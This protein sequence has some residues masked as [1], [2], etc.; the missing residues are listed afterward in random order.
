[1]MS[2]RA[3]RRAS[4]S[5]LVAR[6]RLMVSLIN[7]RGGHRAALRWPRTD[8]GPDTGRNVLILPKCAL[9]APRQRKPLE[10]HDL[11]TTARVHHAA[12]RR[13]DMAARGARA[14][15]RAR[16]PSWRAV[17]LCRKRFGSAVD[18]GGAPSNAAGIGMGGGP[19]PS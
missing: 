9:S 18:G 5:A 10:S 13:G 11:D 6:V 17:E 14:A 7:R 15:G 16:A 2:S 8:G 1:M 19:Q 4:T 3:S 12:R